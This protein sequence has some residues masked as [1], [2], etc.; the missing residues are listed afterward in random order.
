MSFPGAFGSSSSGGGAVDSVNGE[1][2]IVVLD[3]SDIGLSEVDNTSD[4]DKPLSTSTINAL[5]LKESLSNK[6]VPSGYAS[7]DGAGH[8]PAS[9]LP[10]YVDDVVEY[11]DFASLPVT[12]ETG[13][14]YVT[15]DTNL[16]YR[17]SGS[18]YVELTDTTAVWGNVSGLLSNQTDLNNELAAINS[19]AET[20]NV[21]AHGVDTTSHTDPLIE[22]NVDTTLFDVKAF[23]YYINGVKYQYAGVTGQSAGF[24]SGDDFLILGVN[25]SGLVLNTKNTFFTATQLEST[26]EIGG[27]ATLNGS[28]ISTVGDAHFHSNEFIRNL[29]LWSKL[30][31]STD[32]I[33][34]AGSVGEAVTPLRLSIV[35]GDIID[36]DLNK[37]SIAAQPEIQGVVEY[38]HIAGGWEFTLAPDPFSVSNLLYDDGTNLATLGNNKWASHTIARSSRTGTI[39]FIYSQGEFANESE[40][41]DAAPSIGGFE[42]QVGS[43]IEPLAKLVIQKSS[44]SINSVIDVRGRT[45]NIVSAST[46]TMQTTYD[47][48]TTPEIITSASG[49]AVTIQGGTGLDADSV[50]EG[51]SNAGD[52]TFALT[53]N[54]QLV[55]NGDRLTRTYRGDEVNMLDETLVEGTYYRKR[56]EVYT[57]GGQAH[58]YQYRRYRGT[59]ATPTGLLDG[60]T[61]YRQTFSGARLTT[62]ISSARISVKVEGD[63]TDT[64]CALGFQFQT[65]DSAGATNDPLYLSSNGNVGLGTLTPSAKLDVNGNIKLKTASVTTS[66]TVDLSASTTFTDATS[67]DT[68]LTIPTAVANAGIDLNII[69]TDGSANSLTIS[70]SGAELI[71]GQTSFTINQYDSVTLISNGQNWFVK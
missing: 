23:T 60:D 35:G 53:A 10:S 21:T 7:L 70:A 66:S 5:L 27:L 54:G 56:A 26:L 19:K 18:I 34:T 20:L 48:S 67:G 36:P 50:Y 61:V 28:N 4:L 65:I 11:A 2:G 38:H 57:E 33:G 9:E 71:S 55:L 59:V 40:A 6:G 24:V 47:R 42:G 29:Y 46:S 32:F 30:A 37:E 1:T 17:W 62:G 49:G 68:V 14:I 51:K 58:D 39:Y 25:A 63:A 22:I 41:I 45:S 31:K 15:L 43:E 69:R 13:K 16:T 8:V 12:G 3:K 52:T 64:A 44:A